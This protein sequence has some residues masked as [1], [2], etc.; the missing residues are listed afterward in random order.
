MGPVAALL[1][2]AVNASASTSCTARLVEVGNSVTATDRKESVAQKA[3]AIREF[4]VKANGGFVIWEC[5]EPEEA[6]MTMSFEDHLNGRLLRVKVETNAPE[7]VSA[8]AEGDARVRR[9]PVGKEFDT[10]IRPPVPPR[11]EPY[12]CG[13]QFQKFVAT[14]S[15]ED[16][17]FTIR[18]KTEQFGPPVRVEA[19]F[20]K[21]ECP[22]PDE[23]R[24]AMRF[25]PGV[26]G[27]LLSA[28]ARGIRTENDPFGVETLSDVNVALVDFTL[29]PPAQPKPKNAPKKD[30]K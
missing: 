17:Q 24:M 21:W 16:T 19:K 8:F 10:V 18:G 6:R 3:D 14:L 27:R 29:P 30:R 15:R 7:R 4:M 1:A 2:L 12:A 26:D 22:S 28:R 25:E 11:Y 9:Q 5:P 20:V 13:I 23:G